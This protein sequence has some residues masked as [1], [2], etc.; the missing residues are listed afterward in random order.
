MAFCGCGGN[1][2]K[3]AQRTLGCVASGGVCVT[4][5]VRL[6]YWRAK[7]SEFFL[8]AF[9]WQPEEFFELFT[10][11]RFLQA[12]VILLTSLPWEIVAR[13]LLFYIA[14]DGSAAVMYDCIYASKVDPAR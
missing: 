4:R 13:T 5:V 9:H 10:N 1:Q 8:T 3:R 7:P 12:V 14:Y 6:G 11:R 2:N